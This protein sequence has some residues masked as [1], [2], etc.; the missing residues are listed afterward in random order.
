[1][2][3]LKEYWTLNADN[4]LGV[5]CPNIYTDH[6]QIRW[7]DKLGKSVDKHISGALVWCI[8]QYNSMKN[9]NNVGALE[10]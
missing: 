2:E 6:A 10:F 8:I 9:L 4:W 7:W 1:M 5:Y 3:F